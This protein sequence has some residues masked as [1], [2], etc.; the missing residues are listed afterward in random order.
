VRDV[1]EHFGTPDV[2]CTGGD[3][4]LKRAGHGHEERCDP[5]KMQLLASLR[6]SAMA[7]DVNPEVRQRRRMKN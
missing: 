1:I 6:F 5:R 7:S 4:G 3:E 2:G